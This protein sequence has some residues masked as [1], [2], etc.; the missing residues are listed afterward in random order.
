MI[1]AKRLTLLLLCTLLV[2]PTVG[3][4]SEEEGDEGS[5]DGEYTVTRGDLSVEVSAS[6]NLAFSTEEDLSFD[7]AGT[8]EDVFVDEG[9][10]VTEGEV[11]ATLDTEDWEDQLRS[12]EMS[13]LS[14]EIS[15][16]QAEKTLEEAEEET[17]TTITGDVV[18]QCCP[19]D[20][21]IE[22]KEMQ[23]EQAELKLEDAQAKLDEHLAQSPEVVA[24]FDGFV[25]KVTAEGGD[26]VFK[27][28]IAVTIVD[29]N[30]FE[31]L[32]YVSENDI[33][34]VEEGTQAEVSVDSM[35]GVVLPAEVT[36]IAPTATIS[37]G[38][39]NYEVTVEVASIEEMRAQMEEARTRMEQAREEAASSGEMTDRLK[40]AVESGQLTQEEAD[41]MVQQA[42][43]GGGFTQ[44][45][46]ATMSPEDIELR[47]GLS[48][49]VTL[50]I[51]DA[52]D[53]LLVPNAAISK[54]GNRAFVTL[55]LEDGSEEQR[56][57]TTG[58]SSWQYTEVVSGLEEGDIIK[59]ASAVANNNGPERQGGIVM[60]GHP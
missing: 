2:L 59:T 16:R 11:V 24:P 5:E 22:I 42:E 19:D 60:R 56:S 20:E 26:E 48:V 53:V 8:V 10:A 55:I 4:T 38:V 6:G 12:L 25:T 13:V 9:D 3:C 33:L 58:V 43:S 15:L 28:S 40:E 36:A 29:P 46:A 23:V 7:M 30:R 37:S 14:A 57:I 44:G 21:E 52:T 41:A 32:I 49:S 39:V 31:A 54:A 1:H 27:G 45:M 34:Q 51:T 35:S 50:L 18:V 17:Q 47:E